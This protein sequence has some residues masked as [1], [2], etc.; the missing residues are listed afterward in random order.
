M[1]PRLSELSHQPVFGLETICREEGARDLAGQQLPHQL[2]SPWQ[3]GDS[4]CRCLSLV[5]S[6]SM[7]DSGF[8][9][10]EARE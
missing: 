2:V 5:V 1:W 7:E 9:R 4:E 10:Q 8:W 3:G 6:V